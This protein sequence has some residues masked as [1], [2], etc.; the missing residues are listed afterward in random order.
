MVGRTTAIDKEQQ[1]MKATQ[2]DMLTILL[3]IQSRLISMITPSS[4]S[5]PPPTVGPTRVDLITN[6]H[7]HESV[8]TRNTYTKYL[9]PPL[10]DG[11]EFD[12]NKDVVNTFLQK[13]HD[14]HSLKHTPDNIRTLEASVTLCGAEPT[15]TRVY[16]QSSRLHTKDRKKHSL[17]EFRIIHE[18]DII[19]PSESIASNAEIH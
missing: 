18:V 3:D 8:S 9:K 14:L 13:W 2:Q 5:L 10:Y 7:N 1:N 15:S 4:T 6:V 19:K 17:L 11:E 16:T 12:Y